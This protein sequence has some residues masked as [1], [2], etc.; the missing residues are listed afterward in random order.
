MNDQ[1]RLKWSRDNFCQALATLEK[2]VALPILNDRDRAG[3]IQGFE[4]TFELAWKTLQKYAQQNG[5]QVNGPRLSLKEALR[6]ALIDIAD[7]EAWL[8]MLDDRNLTSHAYKEEVAKEVT[9]RIAGA[10]ISLLQ[11]LAGK[12]TGI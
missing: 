12:L 4:Y 2:F 5:I 3:I 8:K 10:H 9:T 11:K 7:E 6:F 1:T